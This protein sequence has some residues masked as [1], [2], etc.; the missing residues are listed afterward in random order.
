MMPAREKLIGRLEAHSLLATRARVAPG[1][2]DHDTPAEIKRRRLSGENDGD[3]GSQQAE[4]SRDS[5]FLHAAEVQPPG[6]QGLRA[7]SNRKQLARADQPGLVADAQLRLSRLDGKYG[8]AA[9]VY[10]NTEECRLAGV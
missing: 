3:H 7:A 9:P 6:R 5:D 1:R 8:P 4:A 2:K 10:L